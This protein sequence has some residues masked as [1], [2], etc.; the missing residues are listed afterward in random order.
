MSPHMCQMVPI[1][2]L[3]GVFSPTYHSSDQPRS[4]DSSTGGAAQQ[5]EEPLDSCISSRFPAGFGALVVHS[6]QR[7]CQGVLSSLSQHVQGMASHQDGRMRDAMLVLWTA[8]SQDIFLL[9]GKTF[10]LLQ[11][12]SFL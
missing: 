7:P 1:T 5:R 3:R 8:N 12:V 6:K 11:K 10:K 2:I 4:A 9:T